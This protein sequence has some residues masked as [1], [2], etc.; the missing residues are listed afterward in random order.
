REIVP[1]HGDVVD[2]HVDREVAHTP[3]D[4]VVV[5]RITRIAGTEHHGL[6]G[7][8]READA[9]REEILLHLDTAIDR[10]APQPAHH[11]SVG[12]EVENLDAAI[13]M[14]W[15]RVVLPAHAGRYGEI[16]R[17]LELVAHV[18]PVFP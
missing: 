10:V 18:D 3:A 5:L 6:A 9:W 12:R 16:A 11:Q 15:H 13:G 1:S 17:Q 4:H 14:H 8:V 7:A 2:L